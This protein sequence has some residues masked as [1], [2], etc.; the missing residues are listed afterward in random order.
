MKRYDVAGWHLASAFPLPGLPEAE[1]R[2]LV[3]IEIVSGAVPA[4]LGGDVV[5]DHLVF[6]VGRDGT[7]LMT[8]PGLLRIL[9]AFGRRVT[10]HAL[11]EQGD[12]DIGML[13]RG[14]VLAVLARQRGLLPFQA[15]AIRYGDG[16]AALLGPSGC[17]KSVL[18]AMLARRGVEVLSDGLCLIAAGPDGGIVHPLSPALRL[19]RDAWT[20]LGFGDSEVVACRPDCGYGFTASHPA[21]PTLPLRSI[22]FVRSCEEMPGE[23]VMVGLRPAEMLARLSLALTARPALV[24]GPLARH[25]GGQL[26]GVAA[27]AHLVAVRSAE[28]WER[29]ERLADDIL[30]RLGSDGGGM[31]R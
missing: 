4:G 17:G 1:R 8:I 13:L 20:A 22:V 5:V 21:A 12:G 26:A 30:E 2:D 7:V 10:V 18:T 9:I 14:P 24:V 31:R 16:A 3:D 29:A 11:V 6:T 28:S 19:W 15:S 25:L 27:A 23:E